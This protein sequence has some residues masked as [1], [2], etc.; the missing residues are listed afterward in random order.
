MSRAVVGWV[1]L[2]IGIAV[3]S[4][5]APAFAAACTSASQCGSGFCVDGVC[6]NTACGGGAADDCQACAVAAG[7]ATDGI[8]GPSVL[9]R[10]CRAATDL[11]DAAEVCNGT[12]LTCPADK[13]A[14]K[15]VVC[16]AAAGGCD[17]DDKCDGL[18]KS[19]PANAFRPNTYTCRAKAGSCDVV[20]KCTGTSA[21]CPADA[22]APST[23]SCRAKAGPC[24]VAE[25]C[26][27]AA[28]DCPADTLLAAG[29]VCRAASGPCDA[30]E[31]CNG[32]ATAC[33][34]DA[35][36]AAGSVC[37]DPAGG[38]DIAETC[39]GSAKSCPA[40]KFLVKGAVCRP[41]AGSCDLA[42]TCAG[43]IATCPADATRPNGTTCDDGS[44]CTT[45]DRCTAGV[46]GGTSLVCT[47][48]DQCHAAGVCNPATGTCSNPPVADG[49]TCSD[50]SA[51]TTADRCT[52][53]ACAGTPLVCTAADTCHAA[54]VCN[55]ATG[56]CSNPP[57][58]DGTSCSDGSPCTTADRCTAGACAGTPLVCTAA[59]TCHA[60]GVCNPATGTCSNPPVADGTTCSDGNAC[61]A[62]ES[63]QAGACAP[64]RTAC[65]LS[66]RIATGIY[67]TCAIR[68]GNELWC[69]GADAWGAL[70]TGTFGYQ[71]TPIAVPAAGE[72]SAVVAGAS[73][74]CVLRAD[75]T[76]ACWGMNDSGQLGDPMSVWSRN[77]PGPAV[78]GLN[79]VAALTAG[80]AHT[81]A[82]LDTGGVR[83][84]GRN[85]DAQLGD[86]TTTTSN[87]PVAVVGLP[88]TAKAIAAGTRHTC[89]ILSDGTVWCWGR[90]VE[91]QL[92]EGTTGG[93][94]AIPTQVAGLVG[95][96]QIAAGFEHACALSEGEG[97]WCWG[98]NAFGQ[99]GLAPTSS[100]SL[101]IRLAGL[102][103]AR[104]VVAGIYHTCALLPDGSGRCWGF[105]NIGQL[106]DGTFETSFTQRPVTGLTGAVRLSAGGHHNCAVLN[107]AGDVACWGLNTMG[108]LGDGTTTNSNVPH[109]VLG[110]TD[111]TCPGQMI[112]CDDGNPCTADFCDAANG[113]GHATVADGIACND[114]D[115]CTTGE[116]CLAGRCAG[117][118]VVCAA[119]QCH[120]AGICDPATG[121]C[122][123]SAPSADGAPC[124]DGAI[125]TT[126]DQ[127][128]GGACTGT[129]LV[130]PDAGPCNPGACDQVTGACTTFPLVNG[131]PCNDD[132]ACTAH[133][134]CN[135]G[136]CVGAIAAAPSETAAELCRTAPACD[137]A[138]G[139]TST[140]AVNEGAVCGAEIP[141]SGFPTCRAG[142]CAA[143]LP[144]PTT[145]PVGTEARDVLVSQDG[146]HAYVTSADGSNARLSIVDTAT[147]AV[148]QTVPLP[149]GASTITAAPDE[150]TL[151]I[152]HGYEGNH[153]LVSVVELGPTPTVGAFDLGSDRYPGTDPLV[154]A[155]N[156][157]LYA[158]RYPL[159]SLTTIDP[160]T[161]D[162]LARSPLAR[163]YGNHIALSPNG[164]KLYVSHFTPGGVSVFDISQPT[165]VPL[166]AEGFDVTGG[167]IGMAFLPNSS[168]TALVL[169][170][171]AS[172]L[173]IRNMVTGTMSPVVHIG[174]SHSPA[175]LAVDRALPIAYVTASLDN[176]LVAFDLNT[177]RQR[178]YP[179]GQGPQQVALSPSGRIAYVTNATSGSLSVIPLC[180]PVPLQVQAF[181]PTPA[182]NQQV[183]FE[184]FIPSGIVYPDAVLEY[185]LNQD[186][187]TD[188]T[189]PAVGPGFGLPVF[190]AFT[191]PGPYHVRVRLVY[192]GVV[193][194]EANTEVFV[195]P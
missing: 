39:S 84:W 16:R 32:T 24:D 73:H 33:P 116:L 156:G 155:P 95:V 176:Q 130:C 69:W 167:A 111:V 122:T 12:K 8:C 103:G 57:V 127:C 158:G 120:A 157:R 188:L 50:G 1:S 38:C 48:S 76:V 163:D 137:P 29:T 118:P 138:T 61:T 4:F 31:T 115:A 65:D 74:T 2:L 99:L 81:C 123:P 23:T 70:G 108:H 5:E 47:A 55:P 19:C 136:V 165:P 18:A 139:I 22:F 159:G 151:F 14:A 177:G 146:R 45:A 117:T 13:V 80:E 119:A 91:G 126:G 43:G 133:D 135:A 166:P 154:Y 66:A 110:L 125:C 172:D 112:D 97:V 71:L 104:Q 89:A 37:R 114:G 51:C 183:R 87:Y 68:T 140:H 178:R 10:L 186:Q 49:T 109:P 54:G 173:F 148:V 134:E 106:G 182:V 105:N 46:C 192:S 25:T 9:G 40:N 44:A 153:N 171:E 124:D 194:G 86:G 141:C 128:T 94:R 143:P 190:Y 7:G 152:G 121:A 101:P 195:H 168:T 30:T 75:R 160:E 52:A 64:E 21:D 113:C 77:I 147:R 42:E 27:G 6:C 56:A 132:N 79:G 107:S 15:T 180:G 59:D 53:G 35:L 162:V 26:T 149:A 145:I 62:A 34:T 179:T 78:A 20:D 184:T 131:S 41:A 88:G 187:N 174:A 82:L 161:G 142:N 150:S 90:N 96:T 98:G 36:L 164:D 181:P 85:V 60:A 170:W 83:C 17:L 11:C 144:F 175:G 102:N 189:G 93:A 28:A 185:D 67:H 129:P 58:A 191:A 72:V 100:P 92:G 3:W 63:C 193:A 169:G